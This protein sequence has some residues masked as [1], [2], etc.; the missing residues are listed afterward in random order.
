MSKYFTSQVGDNRYFV[1][2]NIMLCVCV[3]VRLQINDV[4][5]SKDGLL[6]KMLWI[7]YLHIYLH[8]DLRPSETL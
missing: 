6:Y 5:V 8:L 7:Y 3:C 4:K 2:G 1:D